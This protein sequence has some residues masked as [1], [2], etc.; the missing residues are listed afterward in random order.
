MFLHS[1]SYTSEPDRSL[2]LRMLNKLFENKRKVRKENFLLIPYD[3]YNDEVN[4]G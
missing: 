4:K 2:P 1:S 3:R